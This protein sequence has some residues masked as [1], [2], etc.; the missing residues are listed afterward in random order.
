LYAFLISPCIATS[1][2]SVTLQHATKPHISV[3]FNLITYCGAERGIFTCGID[4]S[5]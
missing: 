1:L 2:C 4:Q 3:H 5:M